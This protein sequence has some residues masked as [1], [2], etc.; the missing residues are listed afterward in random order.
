VRRRTLDAFLLEQR[1]T[2][3]EQ[4][5]ATTEERDG[6]VF[7]VRHIASRSAVRERSYAAAVSRHQDD[8]GISELGEPESGARARS[9]VAPDRLVAPDR[10]P[11]CLGVGGGVAP[12]S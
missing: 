5:P 6:R 8:G 7:V 12:T 2:L 9:P 4:A 1:R 11:R 10:A 3:I